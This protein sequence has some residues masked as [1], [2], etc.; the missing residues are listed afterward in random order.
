MK[1]RCAATINTGQQC[2]LTTGHNSRHLTLTEIG[3]MYCSY[4][5]GPP[6]DPRPRKERR[7]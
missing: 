1:R 5:W 4:I 7:R 6:P 2:N 3:G